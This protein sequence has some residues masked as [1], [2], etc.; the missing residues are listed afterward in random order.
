MTD[1]LLVQAPDV[2]EPIAEPK[3]DDVGETT[4]DSPEIVEVDD[5][6]IQEA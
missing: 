1:D 6:T 3:D 4:S 2:G 5:L